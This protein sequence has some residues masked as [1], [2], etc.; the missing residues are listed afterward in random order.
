MN[1]YVK[2]RHTTHGCAAAISSKSQVH[3]LLIAAALSENET[4]VATNIIS[5]D[6]EATVACLTQMG[7][8]ITQQSGQLSIKPRIHEQ[9]EECIPHLFCRESGS[10]ARFLLPVA[11]ARFPQFYMEGSGKLPERP[12][13]PICSALREHGC[14]ISSDFLPLHAVGKITSG[15]YRIA[16]NVSSQY[17]SGLLFA[18]PLLEGD[19]RIMLTTDLE[20]AS[21]VDMTLQV[22]SMF[23]I[24]VNVVPFGF[25]I[26][27]GQK[28]QSPGAVQA[29]GDWS[30]A[31]FF[32]GMGALHNRIT[33]TGLRTDSLQGDKKITELLRQ[34][35]AKVSISEAENLQ[36][37]T[38]E[39][40]ELQAI[41]TDVSQIPDLVPALS[42]IAAG[43]CGESRFCHA[44]RLRMKESD[45][46]ES[47]LHMLKELGGVARTEE[48][49][50]GTTLCVTGCGQLH[51]GTVDGAGDHR[52][53]MAAA[54]A[55]C[56]TDGEVCI[57]GAD[58]V[59]KSYP[60]FFEDYDRCFLDQKEEGGC[61]DGIT[62]G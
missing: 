30:N 55:A 45:R 44:E 35:G 25:E 23:G 27:G 9:A 17:I 52:I 10:T 62:V 49:S 43:A 20:S 33:V 29:E 18:L 54:M 41:T 5:Q 51:G 15:T 3:R 13:A 11:A 56:I 24:R 21:Y 12:F 36:D 6:M 4:I 14:A 46:I 53:V 32:L 34:F 42:V 8:E 59:N 60:S 22:I 26:P 1:T 39:G 16:G 50:E 57:V 37:V 40:K 48:T 47:I 19:S 2:S 61:N 31:A 7:C 28:Y 38:V 58:A